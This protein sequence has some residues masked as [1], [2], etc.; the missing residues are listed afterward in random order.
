MRK[1]FIKENLKDYIIRKDIVI[2]KKTLRILM[3][4]FLTFF[5]NPITI[6]K[7]ENT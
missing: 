6:K 2:K 7:T 5:V 3:L 4:S 1:D